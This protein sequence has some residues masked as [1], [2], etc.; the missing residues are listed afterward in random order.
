MTVTPL[1]RVKENRENFCLD[2]QY[3]SELKLGA[4]FSM[5]PSL[6]RQK[7]DISTKLENQKNHDSSTRLHD[8]STSIS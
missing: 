2:Y 5:Y 6:P 3:V 1:K 4:Q 7:T 8:T